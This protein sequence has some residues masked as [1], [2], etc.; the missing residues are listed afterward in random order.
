MQRLY[1]LLSILILTSLLA[2]C[3]G[4]ANAQ[5]EEVKAVDSSTPGELPDE[6]QSANTAQPEV[7]PQDSQG[8]GQK[9]FW[10]REGYIWNEEPEPQISVTAERLDA[11]ATPFEDSVGTN[12][13]ASDIGSAMLTGVS[14]ST[15]GCWKVTGEYADAEL[16]FVIW[17]AP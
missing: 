11:P 6:S 17:I 10:W 12:A 7:L 14:F 1:S 8:Y 3:A 16:S 2:G 15:P 4:T 5:A 9:V 13:Y